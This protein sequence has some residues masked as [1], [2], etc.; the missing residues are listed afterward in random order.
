MSNSTA[1]TKAHEASQKAKGLK[2]LRRLWAYPADEDQIRVHAAKLT[3]RRAR[4]LAA[5]I[6]EE[7]T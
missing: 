1:R 5:A 4:V 3:K 6:K 7:K 2:E